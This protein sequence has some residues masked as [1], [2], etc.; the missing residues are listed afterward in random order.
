MKKYIFIGVSLFT[1]SGLFGQNKYE[2][3][4]CDGDT[5]FNGKLNLS[6]SGLSARSFVFSDFNA[7]SLSNN[8][9]QGSINGIMVNKFGATVS[10]VGDVAS[11]DNAVMYVTTTENRNGLQLG[12]IYKLTANAKREPSAKDVSVNSVTE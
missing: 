12:H 9:L 11:I 6:S 4:F 2:N 5:L 1:F 7:S 10:T 8:V 3:L